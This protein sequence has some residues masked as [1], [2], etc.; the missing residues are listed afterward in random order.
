MLVLLLLLMCRV[1]LFVIVYVLV[2]HLYEPCPIKSFV[3]KLC[4]HHTGTEGQVPC[5]C[6]YVI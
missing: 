6:T 4:V 3:Y 2:L 1:F 5:P